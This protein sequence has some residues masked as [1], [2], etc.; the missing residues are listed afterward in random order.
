MG[1]RRRALLL[2]GERLGDLA[3][4]AALQVAYL[5]GEPFQGGA[6]HR[7]SDHERGVAVAADYLG[8]GR[9]GLEAQC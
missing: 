1:H 7:Q 4:F 5:G 8:G 6:D 2:F 3:D 9:L